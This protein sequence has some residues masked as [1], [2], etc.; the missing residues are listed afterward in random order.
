MKNIEVFTMKHIPSHIILSVAKHLLLV[1]LP[2]I[3]ISCGPKEIAPVDLFPEDE[4]A[5]CRMTVSVPQFASEIILKDGTSVKFDDLRCLEKF[6]KTRDVTEIAAIFVMNY[7]TKQWMPFGKSIVIQTGIETPMGSGQ[8]AVA[9][10]KR[11]IQLKEQYPS[12][13]A[14][15]EGDACCGS[16]SGKEK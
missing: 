14:V 12:T 11:A 6:R 15:M 13:V 8:V 10:Q 3:L 4:C 16:T 7:D 2:I 9:D 1:A 5:S